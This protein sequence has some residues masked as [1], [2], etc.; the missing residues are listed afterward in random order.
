M[1]V[2]EAGAIVIGLLAMGGLLALVAAVM[3]AWHDWR[4]GR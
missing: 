4:D 3:G 1:S 2:A